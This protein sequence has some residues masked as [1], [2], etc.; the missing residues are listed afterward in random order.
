M[1]GWGD[2]CLALHPALGRAGGSI[3]VLLHPRLTVG[4]VR[5]R[6]KQYENIILA[7]YFPRFFGIFKILSSKNYKGSTPLKK[8]SFGVPLVAQWLTNLTRNHEV[9]G[10]IP[11]LTQWVK[12]PALP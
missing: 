5:S 6:D 9:A 11:G 3:A 12:D 7:N 4:L 1:M 8:Y 10:S 2:W